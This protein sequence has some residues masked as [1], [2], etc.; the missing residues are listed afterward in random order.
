MLL[1]FKQFLSCFLI[2]S[3]MIW[4]NHCILSDAFAAVREV[5]SNQ[6]PCHGQSKD[7]SHHTKCEENSCC[8]PL[9]KSD[10]SAKVSLEINL[11][12][13]FFKDENTFFVREYC[14]FSNLNLIKSTTC[15][16]KY[17]DRFIKSLSSAPQAPPSNFF[18]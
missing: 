8:Q 4:A 12:N 13:N 6:A 15:P 17:S 7:R 10:V 16:P 9:L 1:G 3:L 14:N 11:I 18:R 2:L 5:S